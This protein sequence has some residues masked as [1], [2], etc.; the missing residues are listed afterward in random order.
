MLKS[1]DEDTRKKAVEKRR[2]QMRVKEKY[3]LPKP[4]WAIRLNCLQCM[5]GSAYEVRHCQVRHCALF[6]YRL[7]RK[8][9]EEDL[10]FSV[11]DN[12][13]KL[14]GQRPLFETIKEAV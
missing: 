3:N 14:V 2:Q 13:G 5:C 11:F 7:G 4:L 10:M 1:M 12:Q 9:T 8:P 6:P